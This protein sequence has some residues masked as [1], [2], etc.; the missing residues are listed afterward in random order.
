MRGEHGRSSD[1]PATVLRRLRGFVSR[2]RH[3]G[4]STVRVLLVDLPGRFTRGLYRKFTTWVNDGPIIRLLNV[5]RFG[6]F[7][8]ARVL[9]LHHPFYVVVMPNTLHF[10]V[11]CLALIPQTVPVALLLNG[12]HAW[13]ERYLT[14]HYHDCPT[15][16]LR[17]FPGSSL[18][19]GGVLN[20][21]IDRSTSDFGILD[22]DMYIFSPALF[23]GLAL[24]EDE[25]AIGALRLR[26]AKA[27]LDFPTTHFLFLNA[28]LAKRLR[29]RYGIGA[30][31]Y[32]RIPRNV[33]P[34]LASL[35][36]GYH[37]FLKDYHDYFDIFTLMFALALYEKLRF[38]FLAV[39]SD[40]VYHIG[41]T[42]RVSQGSAFSSY[43]GL[44]FIEMLR[45]ADVAQRY[46]PLYDSATADRTVAAGL[47]DSPGL[48]AHVA[49]TEKAMA[50]IQS[51]VSPDSRRPRESA[52]GERPAS[53]AGD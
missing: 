10:L 23:D 8:H 47:R 46:S 25:L 44:R 42:S 31:S 48:A 45:D 40:D 17:A 3:T 7:H 12:V 29:D 19:H 39:A 43:V 30:Q 26:N 24:A 33:G 38:R 21:L 27:G 34:M 36:L 15:F 16:R 22:H 41:S 14:D 35:G 4:K 9:E 5:R 37:N 13:E 18:S 51:G 11:P 52:P 20:L 49:T 32:R 53:G 2:R 50:R 1:G 6:A 28:T